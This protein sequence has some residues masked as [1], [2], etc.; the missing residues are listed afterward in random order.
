MNDIS[1]LVTW[2]D[3]LSSEFAQRDDDSQVYPLTNSD[4]DGLTRWLKKT[5]QEGHYSRVS[6]NSRQ[7]VDQ[8]D[9]CYSGLS[10]LRF[11][12]WSFPT[13]L[14]DF[15]VDQ[16]IDLFIE[17]SPTY[18]RPFELMFINGQIH[19]ALST[20]LRM[21]WDLYLLRSLGS[22]LLAESRTIVDIGGGAGRH[23]LAIASA[24]NARDFV[25]LDVSSNAL[26]VA[27]A[28]SSMID[29][30]IS[31]SSMDYF[32][33]SS[34]SKK[35]DLEGRQILLVGSLELAGTS[36]AS[37]FLSHLLRCGVYSILA[38]EPAAPSARSFESREETELW[39]VLSDIYISRNWNLG[40]QECLRAVD[41]GLSHYRI[42]QH[43]LPVASLHAPVIQV[44]HIVQDLSGS[45]SQ[46]F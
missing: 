9:R 44:T 17:L 39:R 46:D 41:S 4:I 7:H 10:D 23:C 14:Q 5:L 24:L 30:S 22:A 21:R 45:L 20:D 13:R 28:W 43:E 25:L 8:W 37:D 15:A 34:W 40:V 6:P 27:S 33:R 29:L 31:T 19:L 38:I 11:K 12:E 18:S 36:T 16:I 2:G 35:S 1:N 42:T 32:E 3:F 26:G